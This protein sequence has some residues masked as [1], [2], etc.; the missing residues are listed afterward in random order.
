M[1]RTLFL[2]VAALTGMAAVRAD[3]VKVAKPAE[4]AYTDASFVANAASCNMLEV[5]LGQLAATKAKSEAVKKYAEMMVEDHRKASEQ[6]A[7]LAEK[8]TLTVPT[9]L[10][11]EHQKCF[12]TLKD[13]ENFDKEYITGSIKSHEMGVKAFKR[14]IA[15]S[16]DAGI[17]EFALKYLPILESHLEQAKKLQ[18]GAK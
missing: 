13:N 10:N 3:D 2:L 6:I 4:E 16:K 8:A 15:E 18:D 1:L 12:D 14:A 5:Q 7:K 11:A 17:K 9:K